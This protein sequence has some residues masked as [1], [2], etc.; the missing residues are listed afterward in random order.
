MEI[1]N[2]SIIPLHN[3]GAFR[4]NKIKR[5]NH[6]KENYSRENQMSILKEIYKR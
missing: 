5:I 3:H 2:I 6:A 4:K 1:V